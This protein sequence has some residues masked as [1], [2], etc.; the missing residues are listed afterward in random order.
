MDTVVGGPGGVEVPAQARDED[1]N[2]TAGFDGRIA[3]PQELGQ[4]ILGNGVADVKQQQGEQAPLPA[5]SELDRLPSDLTFYRTEQSKVH[6]G[7][8]ATAQYPS[9]TPQAG[10]K[11]DRR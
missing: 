10:R 4:P 8:L 9:T 11:S 2:R 7:S 6:A 5:P 1:L 3:L